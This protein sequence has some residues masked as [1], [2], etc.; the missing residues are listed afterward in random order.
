MYGKLRKVPTK[1]QKVQMQI[2]YRLE[3]KNDYI[4]INGH[5]KTVLCA[6]VHCLQI[7]EYQHLY[8][9]FCNAKI[10]KTLYFDI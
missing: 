2:F 9:R 5:K 4:L 1:A 3:N 6:S 7:A 8:E 10:N